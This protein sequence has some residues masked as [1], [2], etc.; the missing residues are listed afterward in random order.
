MPKN[1]LS[2]AF[3]NTSIARS[4]IFTLK[5]LVSI[6]RKSTPK[7]KAHTNCGIVNFSGNQAVTVGE[8]IIAENDR[9]AANKAIV[10]IADFEVI[11]RCLPAFSKTS[12]TVSTTLSFCFSTGFLPKLFTNFRAT[13]PPI[14][15]PS[16]N[17]KVAEAIPRLVAPSI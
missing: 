12:T 8:T 4:N 14:S 17:P 6:L 15:P 7:N 3:P 11:K 1:R 9:Q 16:T 2:E 5:A 13:G 10:S